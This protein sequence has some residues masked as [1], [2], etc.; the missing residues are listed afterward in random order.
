MPKWTALCLIFALLLIPGPVR[1]QSLVKFNALEVDLWP[2]YDRTGVLVIYHITLPAETTLPASLALRL[3][4]AAGKPNAVAVQ[5]PNG[6]LFSV[7]YQTQVDGDDEII[8]FS[9][10]LLQ[11]QVEYYDPGLKITDK[12]R[13]FSYTWPGNYAVDKMLVQVQQPPD[14]SSLNITPGPV[15]SHV[16]SDNLTYYQKDIGAVTI[17]QTFSLEVTYQK[18]TDSLTVEKLQVQP[19]APLTTAPTWQDRLQVALPWFLGALGVLL[20][21]GGGYWFWK[22]GRSAQPVKR[23]RR[24]R[25]AITQASPADGEIIIYCHQ[26]GK[27]AA[28]GDRFCRSCGTRLRVE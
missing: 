22:S 25:T 6:Q 3:P 27:R 8:S 14:A 13:N 18:D 28:T 21:L 7:D 24:P 4:K 1:G 17:G 23:Y 15:T 20:I 26:C 5:Q 10:T 19:S 12:T 9:A 2:E 16:G 11:V